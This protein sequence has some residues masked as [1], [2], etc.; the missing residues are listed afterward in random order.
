MTFLPAGLR[1]V[2]GGRHP[3]AFAAAADRFART[4]AR[5]LGRTAASTAAATAGAVLLLLL[6][7]W[8]EAKRPPPSSLP[9]AAGPISWADV[10]LPVGVAGA[11]GGA[12]AGSRAERTEG[13]G[14]EASVDATAA[15]AAT[16][17]A[18]QDMSGGRRFAAATAR[19]AAGEPPLVS[20]FGTCVKAVI[21]RE[22]GEVG[23]V[24][25]RVA[26]VGLVDALSGSGCCTLLPPRLGFAA[27]GAGA[28]ATTFHAS[29]TTPPNAVKVAPRGTVHGSSDEDTLFSVVDT[30]KERLYTPE[31]GDH[32]LPR[33]HWPRPWAA[34]WNASAALGLDA[35]GAVLAAHRVAAAAAADSSGNLYRG[36][37]RTAVADHGSDGDGGTPPAVALSALSFPHTHYRLN[38]VDGELWVFDI[39]AVAESLPAT[40]AV[41]EAPVTALPVTMRAAVAAVGG[42]PPSPPFPPSRLSPVAWKVVVA[43]QLGATGGCTVEVIPRSMDTP[44]TLIVPYSN[45]PT[46]LARYLASFRRLRLV[47]PALSLVIVTLA[48]EHGVVGKLV[49]DARLPRSLPLPAFA[50]AGLQAAFT[51]TATVTA[52]ATN[53]S[54]STP[55]AGVAAAAA[56]DKN[57]NGRGTMIGSG[58]AGGSPGTFRGGRGSLLATNGVTVLTAAGDRTGAF[59]R[60]VA[61]REA[62]RLLPFTSLFFVTDVDLDIKAGALRN[63]RAN[64]LLGGQAWFPIF[65]NYH[66][67]TSAAINSSSGYWRTSSYGPVCVHRA[68]WEAVGGFGGDEER[69][70]PGKGSEDVDLYNAFRSHASV[71][72]MRGLEPA[73]SHASHRKGMR[74]FNRGG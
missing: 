1:G 49:K 52:A 48:A 9:P 70:Y 21:E 6:F 66:A 20:S 7:D 22:A 8:Q 68:D 11:L 3:P 27:G 55:C 41:A 33:A 64:A 17:A 2:T 13:G 40:A 69:R 32:G 28:G 30:F 71:A 25:P 16:V 12:T 37:G 56:A 45:R 31:G 35:L 34:R 53:A 15:L 65:W 10:P 54:S 36:T 43:R 18:G 73:L 57:G 59:S 39:D 74:A 58:T 63:C 62:V 14:N 26:E 50:D 29:L 61:I 51:A 46:H 24:A 60:S 42:R 19:L 72:V 5:R 23:G 47:D 44:L 38:V 67:A 4:S